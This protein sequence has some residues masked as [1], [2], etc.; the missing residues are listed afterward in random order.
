MASR[1]QEIAG[2]FSEI[3]DLLEIAGENA[4]RI[5]SYRKAARIIEDLPDDVGKMLEAGSLAEVSG[6]GEHSLQK[7]EEYLKT[8]KITAM[9]DLLKKVPA[10]LVE[11]LKIPGMGPKTV[12]AMW[13]TLGVEDID[14]LVKALR[15][16]QLE[17]L[18]GMGAKKIENIKKGLE[19]LTRFAGRTPLGVALPLA[20]ELVDK[21]KKLHSVKKVEAAGSLRRRAETV[22][23]IDILV[24][25]DDGENVLKSFTKFPQVKE[26]LAAGETKSSVRIINDIQVDVRVV[27]AESFGSAL[28]Y[29]SGSKEHNVHL[30]EMA[31]KKKWKLNEYGLFEGEKKLA[32]ETEEGIY[33]KFDLPWI[34]PELRENRGEIE[35][36][37]NLPKLIELTDIKGDL[38]MHTVASDGRCTI[39]EMIEGCIAKGYQYMCIT[40]HSQ[41]SHV[42]NGLEV[43]R[44]KSHIAAVRKAGEKYRKDIT[45]WIGSEVDIHS[46]GKMDYEDAVLS[47]LDFVIG[48]IH[49]A[50]NQPREKIMTRL[51]KAMENPYVRLIGHPTNRIV[52]SR[53]ASDIDIAELI[54]QAKDTGTWLE[55]N[56]AWQRLDLKDIHLRQAK[57]AGV[58]IMINTDAHDISSLESIQY[59]VFTARRGWLEAK[60]VIN[61]L[62]VEKLTKLLKSKKA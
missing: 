56:A 13:K 37:K 6:I 8:G 59:G 54:R 41:S 55:L 49:A 62:P 15:T 27:P 44:L 48:S 31:V 20:M 16:G 9:D 46:E 19:F 2:I 42:A 12:A 43:S 25:A 21:L 24:Q 10:G 39:E 32:G 47:E 17:S 29:F 53:E 4:F 26:I 11:L 35:A 36:G 28:Q 30:R 14:G 57:E 34:P 45:V 1:N 51:L 22:G 33:A 50:L 52:G 5:N 40:D 61:T 58:K 38:H 3:A 23:D 7:I 18:P 60:D